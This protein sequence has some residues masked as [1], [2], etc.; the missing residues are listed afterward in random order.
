M[1]VTVKVR[2]LTKKERSKC[3]ERLPALATPGAFSDVLE[4]LEE[5]F[6]LPC[7]WCRQ[8][9]LVA[10]RIDGTELWKAAPHL[11]DDKE[12]VMN[13][14]WNVGDAVRFASSTLKG[15][16]DI[17]R[18]VLKKDPVAYQYLSEEAR[19]DKE[20][21]LFAVSKLGANL[22]HVAPEPAGGP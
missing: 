4:G 11:Q 10:V 14:V 17:A 18:A 1:V 9:V 13:A 5:E 16:P 7:T 19:G 20:L 15:D 8:L 3:I 21:A 6:G 12:I 22:E 2:Q